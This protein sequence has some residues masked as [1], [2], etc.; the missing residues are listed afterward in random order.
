MILPGLLHL[1]LA[2]AM[3]KDGVKIC[4][5]NISAYPEGA[6]TGEIAA[7]HLKDYGI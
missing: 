4:S 2:N 7:S 5:Q 3:V 1:S 6:Y